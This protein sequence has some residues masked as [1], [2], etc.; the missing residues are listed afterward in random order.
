[1]L[2]CEVYYDMVCYGK[3]YILSHKH[4]WYMVHCTFS[5]TNTQANAGSIHTWKPDPGT[6]ANTHTLSLSHTQKRAVPASATPHHIRTSR[7][8]SS[9]SACSSGDSLLRALSHGQTHKRTISVCVHTKAREGARARCR[10]TKRASGVYQ[11]SNHHIN[12]CISFAPGHVLM[13]A[14]K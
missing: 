7:S 1:M 12:F 10:A 6:N 13:L 2:L 3:L 8:S 11:I 14:S 5:H 4:T 9:N